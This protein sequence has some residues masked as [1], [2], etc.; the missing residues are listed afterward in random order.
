MNSSNIIPCFRTDI[1]TNIVDLKY[2][3]TMTVSMPPLEHFKTV[4]IVGIKKRRKTEGEA[5]FQKR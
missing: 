4:G 3:P 2:I 1:S 5:E